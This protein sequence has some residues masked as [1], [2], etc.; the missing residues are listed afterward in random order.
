MPRNNLAAAPA[1]QGAQLT[2][3]ASTAPL[4]KR[5]CLDASG[6]LESKAGG[7]LWEGIAQTHVVGSLGELRELL[8]AIAGDP[9]LQPNTAF[10][11][12]TMKGAMQNAR[13]V[14]RTVY[15]DLDDRTGVITRTKDALEWANGPGVMIL[16]RDRQPGELIPSERDDGEEL[17]G[18]LERA[19]P[20]FSEVP[21]LWWA[22][23]SSLIF[24][25]DTNEQL[26]GLSGE[27]MW[28]MVKDATDIE[29]AG[30]VLAKRLWIA[31]LGRIV[32]GGAGQM[33][34]RT[35]VD[36]AVWSPERFDFVGGAVCEAPLEQRRGQPVIYEIEGRD[37]FI[38]T[39]EV[40]PDL[41]D[42]EEV[43]YARLVEM[44]KVE[45]KPAAQRA[46]KAAV[47]RQA[48]EKAGPS[49]SSETLA[50][51]EK[52]IRQARDGGMLAS[53]F[54]VYVKVKG[55]PEAFTVA[56]VVADQQ[57]FHGAITLDPLE[58]GYRD[59]KEVGKLFAN[60][61]GVWLHSM[62][63]GG[64]TY[65]LEG[66]K[67]EAIG[68]SVARLADK[69][70]AVYGEAKFA[71][72]M[73][74]Q[75]ERRAANE[76]AAQPKITDLDN[77]VTDGWRAHVNDQF[78]VEAAALEWLEHHGFD[79]EDRGVEKRL[80][81]LHD[82]MRG[83]EELRAMAAHL[84]RRYL[85]FGLAGANEEVYD[86]VTAKSFGLMQLRNTYA[87]LKAPVPTVTSAAA[88]GKTMKTAVDTWLESDA[89]KTVS[90][91]DFTPGSTQ[92]FTP[93]VT[94]DTVGVNVYREKVFLVAPMDPAEAGRRFFAF[95]QHLVP[96]EREAAFLMNHV[97][98]IVRRPELRGQA[99]LMVSAN[100]GVGRGTF[101]EI[102]DGLLDERFTHTLTTEDF[103]G[104]AAQWTEWE[105]RTIF[106]H[107]DEM[108]SL[109]KEKYS[110]MATLDSRIDNRTSRKQISEKN[111]SRRTAR[112]YWTL[113]A[114]TMEL[115]AIALEGR[116]RRW[117]VL[118]NTEV[119]IEKSR[120][121]AEIVSA[122]Q[123]YPQG[124]ISEAFLHGL[125]RW[126]KRQSFDEGM[127]LNGIDTELKRE[128]IGASEGDIERHLRAV[129][130][131]FETDGKFEAWID[132]IAAGVVL[133]L[134]SDRTSLASAKKAAVVVKKLLRQG[135]SGWIVPMSGDTGKPERPR[136]RAPGTNRDAEERPSGQI[137]RSDKAPQ[138]SPEER[139]EVLGAKKVVR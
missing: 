29:R 55:R 12:G 36:T 74:R 3:I 135:F 139:Y 16:D 59:H 101:F 23:A 43:E 28:I 92:L 99:V 107:V 4:S 48:K 123:E 66:S 21:A 128:V 26:K 127:F 121:A 91:F 8:E 134:K 58:P 31:G 61:E 42:A 7:Q 14:T 132:N 117:T 19:V 94:E 39:R 89:R 122:L 79:P 54:V 120:S 137:A 108:A 103:V 112:V 98:G 17:L 114:A 90:K 96:D 138:Y 118:Q 84:A 86:L 51:A 46:E 20:K 35:L 25:R 71:E 60:G 65:F 95:L 13:V 119:K 82:C 5:F 10:V 106:A 37:D 76:E 77:W 130:S 52:A 49:S 56:D 129:L 9:E 1:N 88:I 57:R 125:C 6:K 41:T 81:M 85:Y 63:H 11:Y 47:E 116:D 34:E 70:R 67:P 53:D 105:E 97:V 104:G 64:A 15:E 2:L 18:Q 80:P 126:L 32:I 136:V 50:S 30:K 22:S 33:L 75:A 111:K 24:N 83:R 102:V 133:R 44:A 124:P 110:A 73:A 72:M 131:E 68:A 27:R 93:G 62:A 113:I 78:D 38:D 40:F 109:G 115:D 87:A 45:A 69:F 100:G